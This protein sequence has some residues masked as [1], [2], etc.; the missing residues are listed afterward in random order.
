[1][2]V[3]FDLEEFSSAFGSASGSQYNTDPKRSIFLIIKP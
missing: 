2:S 3:H 1:M